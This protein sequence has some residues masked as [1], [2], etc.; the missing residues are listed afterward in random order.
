VCQPTINEYDD[1]DDDHVL[2]RCSWPSWN[3][4]NWLPVESN[5]SVFVIKLHGTPSYMPIE[6]EICH[7]MV[8]ICF[9]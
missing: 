3:A 4:W 6:I 5:I 7:N 2:G 1:D 8:I 9:C